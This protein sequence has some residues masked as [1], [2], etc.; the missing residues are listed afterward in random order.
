MGFTP[1]LSVQGKATQ[2]PCDL[3]YVMSPS[4]NFIKLYDARVIGVDLEYLDFLIVGL[5]D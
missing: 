5:E 3:L 2:I 4:V 1:R